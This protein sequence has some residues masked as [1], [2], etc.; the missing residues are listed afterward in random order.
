MKVTVIT[1]IAV[2][3]LIIFSGTIIAQDTDS[4]AT[5]STF[6]GGSGS[7][8]DPYQISTVSQLQSMGSYMR[9]HFILNNDI[10]ASSTSSWNSNYGFKPVGG[11]SWQ[12]CFKGTFDGK[13]YNITGLTINRRTSNYVGLFSYTNSQTSIRNVNLLNVSIH[14]NSYVGG[15][16]GYG[17]GSIENC[18]VT[19]SVRGRS[20]YAGGVIGFNNYNYAVIT[21]CSMQGKVRGNEDVGGFSGHNDGKIV[22]CTMRGNVTGSW[23]VGGFSGKNYER[24]AG[25][26]QIGHTSGGSVVGGFIGEN[27][28]TIVNCYS[29]GSS[30]CSSDINTDAGGFAGSCFGAARKCYSTCSVSNKRG[31]NPTNMGFADS[32]KS[33]SMKG[34]FWDKETTGQLTTGGNATGKNTSDMM[35]VS[36]FKWAG[37]DIA[38]VKN[39]DTE[40][41]Y[42]D[43][44]YDYPRLAYE[45]Y[46]DERAPVAD[47]G[48]D[49]LVNIESNVTFNGS[50]SDDNVGITRYEWSFN[51]NGPVTLEGCNP[52]Y[53]FA[54]MGFFSVLLNVSDEA[55]YYDTDMVNVTVSDIETPVSDAGPNRTVD[56]N[57][58]LDL[59]GTGSTDNV[60]V[61]S[62][63]WTVHD[64][65]A[66]VLNGP[67]PNHTFEEAGVYLVELNVSDLAGNWDTSNMTVTVTDTESPLADAGEDITVPMGG[68]VTF[69]GSGSTDN[70]GIVN[71]T[72]NFED[73]GPVILYGMDPSYTFENFGVYEVFLNV[74]DAVGNWDKD[75]VMVYPIDEVDPIVDAGPD[76]RIDMGEMVLF[77]G[78][79]STDNVE[80]ADYTWTFSDP[81]PVVLGGKT[82]GYR[83][84]NSGVYIVTLN[85]SDISGNTEED[86]M[87]VTVIDIEDPIAEAGVNITVDMGE[88]VILDG[89]GST[90]NVEVTNYTWTFY[91]EEEIVLY[92]PTPVYLF[93]DAGTFVLTLTVSD[94]ESNSATDLVSVEVR[95]IE[96]PV[97]DI[98][99]DLT[100]VFNLIADLN[101][102]SSTDNV[103]IVNYTWKFNDGLSDVELYG[104]NQEHKFPVPGMFSIELIVTDAAGNTDSDRINITVEDPTDPRADP[105]EDRTVGIGTTVYLDGSGSMDNDMIASYN[106]S[107]EYGGEERV[108]E[109][110]NVSFD[111]DESGDFQVFLTVVDR[112][113]NQARDSCT[114]SVIRDGTLTG[115]VLDENGNAVEGATVEILTSDGET[116]T[117]ETGVTGYFTIQIPEGAYEWR[118]SKEGFDTSSGTSSIKALE[119]KEMESSECELT[120]ERSGILLFVLLFLLVLIIVVI[121]AA[122]L[123]IL[124]FRKR[125]AEGDL[126][127]NDEKLDEDLFS[128]AEYLREVCR[129]NNI[130]PSMFDM[131]YNKAMNMKESGSVEQ[132]NKAI[133]NHNR[134]VESM[135]GSRGIRTEGPKPQAA[136]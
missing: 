118:I 133:E 18:S 29:Q 136:Q 71:Y 43:H 31:T 14:G 109:G 63:R 123:G 106:W 53:T 95:D 87:T 19:G 21:N 9:G 84:N 85:V 11:T 135:L 107:F 4:T 94:A 83:F 5:R 66:V 125:S 130:P 52:T 42:I 8:S 37:W 7:R 20:D 76:R 65:E 67:N 16:V 45:E 61:V 23:R 64:E 68:F 93:S 13:G 57:A 124:L 115:T 114:I 15:L 3:G 30:Y 56:M 47:A 22:N 132:A 44:G 78:S 81:D 51:D 26:S 113:G 79:R 32:G 97:S 36:T 110:E 90:D 101:G 28:G 46:M 70:V 69:D 24:I 39:L 72:W 129:A 2:M 111:F 98:G 103:G 40:I 1:T 92:G 38:L 62:Y 100:V 127:E 86:T 54:N 89:S 73:G 6:A 126:K 33:S 12:T 34:N 35:N 49:L 120:G 119:T 10:N 112:F 117:T 88:S 91:D 82:P 122:V 59:D 60:G 134:M 128:R 80:I 25:C 131:N 41:W 105:G 27:S 104:K 55:G 96:H 74:S 99:G 116:L 58:I 121:M 77:D 48:D 17:W 50:G 75:I 108:L 102:A